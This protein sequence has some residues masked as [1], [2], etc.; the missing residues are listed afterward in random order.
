MSGQINRGSPFGEQLY[1]LANHPSFSTYVE[2][3]TWNG[4][5][6]TK[7]LMDGL[8]RREDASELYSVEANREF[9]DQA[10]SYWSGALAPDQAH[11]L[12]LLYGR[13]VEVS[14]LVPIEEIQDDPR[15][16]E[17]PWEE[18]RDRNISEYNDCTN[19]VGDLPTSIDLLL[20]DGGQFSTRAEFLLLKERTKLVILDDTSTFKTEAI[21]EEIRHSPQQWTIIFDY[22]FD[23]NG[24]MMACKN[25]FTH[26]LK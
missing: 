25:E 7:C 19:I 8:L 22:P 26:L 1:N 4:Q 13:L 17:N 3:G 18:W 24:V 21:R 5:G 15:F 12:K 16:N 9:Y 14:S 11:R 10:S 23:R 20:L 2:I 6:S